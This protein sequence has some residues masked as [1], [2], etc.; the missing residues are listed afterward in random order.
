MF[1]LMAATENLQCSAGL[2]GAPHYWSE[3]GI[4]ALG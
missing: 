3:S 4:E 2:R 1:T